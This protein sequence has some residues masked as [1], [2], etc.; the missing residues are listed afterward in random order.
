MITINKPF[1]S[2]APLT[3]YVD[4]LIELNADPASEPALDRVLI[5]DAV[6]TDRAVLYP[7]AQYVHGEG[8]RIFGYHPCTLSDGISELA[9]YHRGVK[10]PPDAFAAL[11]MPEAIRR[12]SRGALISLGSHIAVSGA[13][14]SHDMLDAYQTIT[15]GMFEIGQGDADFA[16]FGA[17]R[18]GRDLLSRYVELQ[19]GPTNSFAA[20]R[21]EV[22]KN[23]E[24]AWSV[25]G[26]PFG[27]ATKLVGRIA[28]KND[29]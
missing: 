7:N 20:G 6:L 5:A 4:S 22:L 10:S 29:W 13:F 17:K 16:A 8:Y 24:T 1:E 14:Y 19:T 2:I 9:L 21:S 15:F 23:I 11:D 26:H 18:I 28:N 27:P 3:E 25:V 12:Q